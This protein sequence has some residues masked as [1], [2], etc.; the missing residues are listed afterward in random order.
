MSLP[1]L[2][3]LAAVG[4]AGKDTVGQMLGEWG[5]H[6][7]ALADELR[8]D[9]LK[10]NPLLSGH[11]GVEAGQ[12]GE[13]IRLADLVEHVGWDEAKR[14][15]EVRRLKQVYGTEV[16]RAGFG[17]G[18][19]LLRLSTSG[20]EAHLSAGGRAV[21]TDLRYDNE[22]KAIRARGGAVVRIT[23]RGG[24]G[25]DAGK[26]ASEAGISRA[27]VDH[28]IH[29]DGTLDELYDLVCDLA[30]ALDGGAVT[31]TEALL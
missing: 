30:G 20:L 10:L 21:V 23:G 2:I 19:W 9:L 3:G 11:P 12:F 26:H 4:R 22:A 16:A 27:L 5:Y 15:P 28:T 18:C 13:P 6:P 14:N 29:N 25:G 7:F 31:T 24:L 1:L 17:V 8:A